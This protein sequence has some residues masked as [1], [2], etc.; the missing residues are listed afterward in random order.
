MASARLATMTS[1]FVS[2]ATREQRGTF[3]KVILAATD[4]HGL[5]GSGSNQ[6]LSLSLSVFIRDKLW[7]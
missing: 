2:G 3:E 1:Q 4:L 7:R 5:N 6:Q